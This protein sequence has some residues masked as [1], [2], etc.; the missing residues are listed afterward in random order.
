M[1]KRVY[2]GATQRG[3]LLGVIRTGGQ[4]LAVTQAFSTQR[5]SDPVLTQL[6]PID[7]L[8]GSPRRKAERWMESLS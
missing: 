4:W 7:A 3:R 1:A 2:R 5:A 8:T 6:V